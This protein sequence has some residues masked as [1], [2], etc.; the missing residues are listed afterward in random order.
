MHDLI[1]ILDLGGAD[2]QFIARAVRGAGVYCE[3]VG[4]SEQWRERG[5][6]GLIVMGEKTSFDPQV[7]AMDVPLLAIGPSSRALTLAM[8]GS[9]GSLALREEVCQVSYADLPLFEGVE[10][11]MRRIIRGYPMEL[12]QGWTQIAWAEELPLAFADEANRRFAMQFMPERND[13]DGIRILTNFLRKICECDGGWNVGEYLEGALEGLRN[14]VGDGCAICPMTGGVDTS[15]C[16]A[17]AHKALGEKA[18]CVLVETGLNAE[19]E[20]ESLERAFTEHMGIPVLRIAAQDRF[21]ARL[22]GISSEADKSRVVKDEFA[23]IIAQ[24]ESGCDECAT[25]L[26]QG[27]IYNDL[28]EKRTQAPLDSRYTVI[29]P[30]R[31]L[32]KHEVRQLG[33]KLGLPASIVSRQ[34][35]PQAGLALRC[36][37]E[38]T[39]E[40]INTLRRADAIFRYIIQDEGADKGLRQYYA[41]LTRIGN[42]SVAILRAIQGREGENASIARISY[43]ILDNAAGRIRREVPQV[44]RVLYDLSAAPYK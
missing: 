14:R 7:L 22:Q 25:L 34:P 30:L 35:L 37:G 27:T 26:V 33:E 20:T 8:G 12:P 39:P 15:V 21:M 23:R 5:A 17:L 18:K 24:Q 29:E 41:M 40:R 13:I 9:V 42:E 16:A 11:G 6:S 10:D 28:L 43:D 19:G 31:T 1:L 4:M 36:L 2:T 3:I 32:F 44:D 38:V